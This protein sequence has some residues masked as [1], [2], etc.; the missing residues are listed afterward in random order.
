VLKAIPIGRRS[1]CRVSSVLLALLSA[2]PTWAYDFPLTS[3][4]IREAYFLGKRQLSAGTEFLPDYTHLIPDLTVGE[5]FVTKVHIETP[6]FQVADRASKALNYS[7]QDAVKEF[8]GKP[9][10]FRMV[11]EICYMVDA[12]LP[13]SVKITVLQNGKEILPAVDDRSAFFPATDRYSRAPDIGEIAWLEFD[14]QKFDSS[15]LTILI[16]TPDDQHAG[17]TFDLQSMR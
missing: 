3:N 6:F 14:P 17:T 12:P 13:T 2:I 1:L 7:A 9:V 4:A 5:G 10:A 11:L 16:D 15:V 8:Y